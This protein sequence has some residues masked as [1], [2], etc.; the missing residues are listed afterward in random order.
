MHAQRRPDLSAR[1]SSTVT[2]HNPNIDRPI[3]RAAP[4]TASLLPDCIDI[5]LSLPG[6]ASEQGT[7]TLPIPLHLPAERSTLTIFHHAALLTF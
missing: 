1:A 7:Q 3:A 5:Q 6:P 2:V 4:T